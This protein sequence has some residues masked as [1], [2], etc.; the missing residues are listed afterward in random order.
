M[1]AIDLCPERHEYERLIRG[2]LSPAEVDRLCDH[3]SAC[4]FCAAAVQTL[5]GEDTLLSLLGGGA[6][7]APAGPE[8]PADLTRR[9]LML[10]NAA[11]LLHANRLAFEEDGHADLQHLVHGN[12]LQV[13]VQQR[14]LDRLI[15]PVDNHGFGALAINGKIE[16]RVVPG[17]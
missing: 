2:E 17:F 1:P 3:V 11:F 14:T 8:V 10:Q 13:D 7:E 6:A 15:L 5:L 4:S 16:N 9:L 12:A